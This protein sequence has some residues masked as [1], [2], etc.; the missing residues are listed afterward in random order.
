[1]ADGATGVFVHPLPLILYSIVKP[2]TDRTAGSDNGA[3]HVLA[4]ATRIGALGKITVLTVLLTSHGAGPAVLIA[5]LP[6]AAANTYLAL[7]V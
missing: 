2:V 4:G 3:L 1:M 7:T 5:V 6:H